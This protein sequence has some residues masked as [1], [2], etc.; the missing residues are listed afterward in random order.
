MCRSRRELSNE[1]LLA[2][3][4]V[5]TAE[6]EPSKAACP[7]HPTHPVAQLNRS[8]DGPGQAGARHLR[9]VADSRRGVEGLAAARPLLAEAHALAQSRPR[10]P[11]VALVSF[12]YKHLPGDMYAESGK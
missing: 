3:I 7:G 1:Y 10:R 5:D 2:K 11:A 9:R 8:A 6:N 4:G 12:I